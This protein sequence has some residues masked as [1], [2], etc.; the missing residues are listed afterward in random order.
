M[1]VKIL[2]SYNFFQIV[3]KPTFDLPLPPQFSQQTSSGL[4][5]NY[6]DTAGLACSA[7][8]DTSDGG[9]FYRKKG[10][11][12]FA[13]HTLLLPAHLIPT[14]PSIALATRVWHIDAQPVTVPKDLG[15]PVAAEILPEDTSFPLPS[16]QLF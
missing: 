5:V 9:N 3:V 4:R 6:S 12:N 16:L 8:A 15:R 11:L 14:P 10:M 2:Q 7:T 1:L 13:E